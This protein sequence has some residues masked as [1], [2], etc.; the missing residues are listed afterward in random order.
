[1]TKV[2]LIDSYD[3]FTYNLVH[4]FEALDCQVTVLKND[5]PYRHL[6]NTHD[7][8][9]LSPGP[10][11]PENAG[12]LLPIISEIVTTKKVLGV[13]LGLQALVTHF[14]GCLINLPQVHHGYADL[15]AQTQE[16][17][18]F[19]ELPKTFNVARY[20]SWA[21]SPTNF[22]EILQITAQTSDGTIMAFEHKNL[23]VF[24][25]QF[26]PESILSEHGMQILKN[27]IRL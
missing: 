12:N 10:G 14:G 25:V 22:P 7:C 17:K 26:H 9:V 27:W 4:Y 18:L 3:S 15:M 2:L 13:C 5:E 21:A 16:N 24:G 20:H 23:P 19:R 11:L 6:L 8:V 1:M